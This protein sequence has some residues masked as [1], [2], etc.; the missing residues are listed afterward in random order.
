MR[1]ARRGPG[2]A[3]GQRW[4]A[5]VC[6]T[7]MSLLTACARLPTTETDG[8]GYAERRAR[9]TAIERW[10]MRGRLAIDTGERSFQA[11]FFW[12]QDEATLTLTVR[13]LL[14]AGS[15]E[16]SGTPAALTV[17]SRG[18]TRLLTQPE[19]ELSQMFGWWLPVT[20]LPDWLV[21]LPDDAF[22]ATPTIARGALVSLDQRLWRLDYDE[23][24]LSEAGLLVPRRVSLRH[25]PLELILTVDDWEPL[26]DDEALN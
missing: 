4:G 5:L 20:S 14:G 11:R 22:P 7:A 6:L 1:H 2:H 23:Y 18:E 26:P 9:L 10:D 13:G 15:F 19:L 24:Q 21:G 17:R 8:L 12:H 16:I 25:A 3:V